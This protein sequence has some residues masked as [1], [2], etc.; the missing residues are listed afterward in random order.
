[1]PPENL[2]WHLAENH[3]HLTR[4]GADYF[5]HLLEF[6]NRVKLLSI[7]GHI[8]WKVSKSC[9][10]KIYCLEEKSYIVGEKLKMPAYTE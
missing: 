5:K 10:E 6:Q 9:L 4:K 7:K 2:E 1:M 3:I 8:Q